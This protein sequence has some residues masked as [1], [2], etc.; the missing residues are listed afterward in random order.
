MELP[1]VPG[2]YALFLA[3]EESREIRI[4]RLGEFVFPA[5][6]LAYIGSARGPGG[7][8]SRLARHLRTS[9]PQVWHVDFLR[10]FTHPVA[11]WWT[12]GAAQR[13]CVWAE[14]MARMP[15]ASIPAAG[16]GSSDCRCP[17]HLFHFP[18]VPDRRTFAQ[19]VGDEVLEV[20]WG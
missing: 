18:A 5:G 10:P 13:E 12:G 16:F 15:D 1:P 11:L 3:L 9:K 14:T 2:T 8:K 4:G 19:V 7:L 20:I 6:V 17:T